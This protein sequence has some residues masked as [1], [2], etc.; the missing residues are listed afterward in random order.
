MTDRIEG[1]TADATRQ[2][3]KFC[4]IGLWWCPTGSRLADN[5]DAAIDAYLADTATPDSALR[6]L[7]ALKDHVRGCQP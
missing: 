7:F 5:V 4:R 1:D 2:T 3:L 6:A